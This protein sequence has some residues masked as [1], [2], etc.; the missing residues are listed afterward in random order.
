MRIHSQLQSQT[1]PH[2]PYLLNKN[3]NK[4]N[5]CSTDLFM[6][7]RLFLNSRR[8]PSSP[9]Q[10]PGTVEIKNMIKITLI[11]ANEKLNTFI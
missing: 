10:V 7:K 4:M 5:F 8:H 11:S 9:D 2:N 3:T 1:T 6:D